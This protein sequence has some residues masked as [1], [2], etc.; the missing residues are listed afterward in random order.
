MKA[1]LHLR[2]FILDKR[3]LLHLL[4]SFLVLFWMVPLATAD[5]NVSGTISTD[6][7]WSLADSPYIVTSG[8]TVK[9]TDGADGIT[10]LTIEPGVEVRFNRYQKLTIGAASGDP[11]ALSARGTAADPIVFTSNEA[12]PAAGDWYNIY[13]YTTTDDAG[14][15]L[16]HCVVEYSGYSQGAIYLNNASL[17]FRNIQIRHSKNKGFYISGSQPVIES[18]QLSDN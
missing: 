8:I 5:T 9:G 11:G 7:T 16:E 1:A 12:S 13:F 2:P 10:T 17:T 15:I 6:T 14:T 4:S 3:N 18:C